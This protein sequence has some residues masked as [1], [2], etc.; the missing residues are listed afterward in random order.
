MAT[1]YP[2]KLMN[3]S[4]LLAKLEST[5]GTAVAVTATADGQ[6]LA[7][8]DR[9]PG[10]FTMNYV[11]DGEVGPSPGNLGM[12]KRVG[13]LG[14]SMQGTVPMR[15]KGG[16]ATYTT[17]VLP[18][19]HS[20]LKASGFDS[21]LSGGNYTYTPTADGITYSSLSGESYKRGE[22]WSFRGGIC[23][24]GFSTDG[25]KI[26]IHTFDL[27]AICDT[28]VAD[29]AMV[30]PTYPT[31]TT[32]EPVAAGITVTMGNYIAPIV[33]SVSFKMNRNIDNPRLDLTAADVLQGFVPNGY[34]PELRIVLEASALTY[35]TASGGFDPY[36]LAEGADALAVAVTIGSTQYN[37]Y[38]LT[39]PQAQISEYNPN[40]NDGPVATTE[41]VWKPYNSTAVIQNDAVQ[42]VFN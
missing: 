4:A 31:L 25:A 42:V 7:L 29:A 37:R 5:Y 34:D 22:K 26:P 2:A 24:W 38:T 13:K 1:S 32:Q 39:L 16:A 23:D 27:R 18:N 21:T 17:A 12:L 3:L 9:F 33:R 28:T 19:I 11:Y 8:S 20:M 10:L 15:A 6:F 30:A 41:L 36:R 14:Q 40:M 35:P